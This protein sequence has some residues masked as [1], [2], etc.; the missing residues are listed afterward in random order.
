VAAARLPKKFYW[1]NP[2]EADKLIANI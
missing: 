1:L 2:P